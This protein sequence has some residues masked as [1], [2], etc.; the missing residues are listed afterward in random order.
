[1]LDTS[2]HP[3]RRLFPLAI[4]AAG[5]AV[6]AVSAAF[7]AGPVAPSNPHGK[8]REDCALC[9]TAKNWKIARVSPKF[10][11]SK[12]GFPLAGAHATPVCTTCHTSL[13]FSQSRTQCVSCHRDPHRGEMGV[14]CARCHGAR[15]FTD[16]GPMVR[17]HQ[18]TSFPLTGAHESVDCEGCHKPGGQG[19]LQFKGTAAE[20]RSCHMDN[21][22]AAKNPDHEAQGFPGTCEGCHTTRGWKAA[23]F[24]HATTAFPLTG[25]HTTVACASC[26]TTS[27]FKAANTA[28]VSCHQADYDAAK[29]PH[30]AAGFQA[31]QCATCHGTTVWSGATGSFDHSKTQFPLT[32]AH[33]AATCNAC[34]ADAVYQGKSTACASCHA[35]NY[36][37]AQ[38]PHSAAAFPA[39]QCGTCHTTAAW[40]PGVVNHNAY[41]FKLTGTHAT[42]ACTGCHGDGVYA[43]KSQACYDCHTANYAAAT[44][45]HTPAAFPTGACATCH[46]TTSFA[47]STF[48]H[49]TTTFPLT[50]AHAA[51]ACAGCHGDGVYKGK[52]HD[53]YTCH[54]STYTSAQPPHTAAAFPTAQC[55]TCHTTTAWNP[56][57]VNHNAFAFKL[58]GAHAAVAC[59]G[60]HGDGVYAAKTQACYGCHTATFAAATPK[61][62]TVA[63][64]T[65]QCGT[66]HTTTAWNPGVVN[67]NAF[68][69]KLTGAHAAVACTGCHGDGVYA[70]KTQ[71]CYGCH[72]ATFASAT[73][74]HDTVAF[75]TAQCGTCHT[76]TAWS[77]GVV[78]HNAFAF[79]LTGAHAAV[80]CTG[81]HGDG[82]Y[83]AKTQ[84]CYG[85][86]ATN[87]AAATPAHSETSFPSAQCATCH[88]TVAF[89]PA[90]FNHAATTFPLTGAHAAAA[91]SGCHGDGVYKGKTHDCYTCHTP[92]YTS[93]QPPHTAA[94][95]PTAQCGTCHTTTAWSPGVVNHNAF[96]FKLTGAH[97]AATCVQCHGDGVYAAKTQACYGCHATNYA[98]ATPVHSETSFPS[99]Q[100]ATC[101]STVAFSPATFNHATTTFPLTGA[102]AA[103]ACAGCHGDGVY[104]GKTHDC[105][106]CHTPTYTSAQPPHTAA[107]FPTAQCGTCHTTT[108][109]SPGVVNHN[110]F[111]FKLT[112]AHV[113]ATC[114]QCHGD[115]VYAAKTQACYG[116]HTANYAAA[117]PPHN[118]TSFPTSQCATCHSTTAFTPATFNHATTAFPLTGAHAAGACTSCHNAT[119]W[120][121][122]GTG[123]NC[124]GCHQANYTGAQ[125][126]VH[127]PTNYP[128]TGCVCHNT[129]A[130]QPATGGHDHTAGGFPLTGSHSLAARTC[131]D[132]HAASGYG[133]GATSKDCY[134]CHRAAYASAIP[135]HDPTNFP[136]ATAT[137]IT[138]HAAANTGHTTWAGGKFANHTW[139][140]IAT[141]THAGIACMD[142]HN[143]PNNLASYSCAKACHTSALA[144]HPARNGFNLATVETQCY[145]CH[146]SGRAG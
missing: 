36:S 21:F 16:R 95:F 63:F 6:S 96:A 82:V 37:A 1:V 143:A 111:A 72:T 84:A 34:H 3:G 52:T 108:A 13:E 76:T 141:G 87:Y 28:C 102:H 62:D 109:W 17:A 89:S 74:K 10:D 73:P 43:A 75:P 98:A 2:R 144:N 132:C 15:S 38:P 103:A 135:M 107:A 127:D 97:V 146:P 61:H 120:A 130:W 20:C 23:S 35:A 105:Y 47:G 83:A 32:G 69:F 85:C 119:T 53:C 24:D 60:C 145:S 91:C 41:A 133:A 67:H 124:Y 88:N 44:P 51:A 125:N 50:G 8:F 99:A 66:C 100:C 30:V 29:P 7:A 45:A 126:P 12:Y 116:C 39:A 4:L 55:G 77:P 131:T 142:C 59:T 40:N 31:S 22:R 94:A 33:V 54:T 118:T 5:L 56:G 106:T 90:T 93:A 46:N 18:L 42:A 104:K 140:P 78:N 68:A 9:H 64:P 134:S 114:V 14:E 138:C 71:A 57:V 128:I 65:A 27:D 110:A 79:K 101:H 113:A 115:G 92:T 137:C 129:T 117:T 58:T 26:H 11:H 80:A 122:A 70:A 123:T 25:R 121:V 81:C 136:T 49:A 139:F 86:H 19:Q 48:N 112:G